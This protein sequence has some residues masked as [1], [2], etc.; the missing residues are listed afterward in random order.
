VED[1]SQ[2]EKDVLEMVSGLRAIPES[3]A[4]N[5]RLNGA[6]AGRQSSKNIRIEPK[7]AGSGID[8]HIA[9]GTKNEKVYMPVVINSTGLVELV[10]NDIYVG[11]G[12]DVEVIAGCGINQCGNE[13]NQHDGIHTF[14]L[15]KDSRAVYAE[16]H[17]ATGEGKG[18]RALNPVTEVF[19][20]ENSYLEI[21]TVQIDGI[22]NTRR[23]TKGTVGK[24]ATLKVREKIMTTAG[25]FAET[26]FDVAMEGEDS[27]VHVISRAVAKGSSRQVFISKIE[28]A[29]RCAGHTECDAILMDSAVV[30][31]IPEITASHVDASLVHEATIG[32]IAGEQLTKLM[33]LGLTKEDAE[34]QIINGFLK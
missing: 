11:E 7:P 1:I 22:D 30:K 21:D 5:I 9:P 14:H 26:A 34:T 13:K 27:G 15:E 3:G 32:K 20:G 2:I 29:N 31:A 28:G 10:Y 6:S 18:E 33:T 25:Q 8:I 12:A 19:L 24:G 4:Y 16:K 17:L 23:I